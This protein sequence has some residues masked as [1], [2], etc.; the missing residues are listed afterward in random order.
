M[1]FHLFLLKFLHFYFLDAVKYKIYNEK[2]ETQS[3][4]R[5]EILLLES[6]DNFASYSCIGVN[7]QGK[8]QDKVTV[9]VIETQQSSSKSYHHQTSNKPVLAIQ[10]TSKPASQVTAEN[11]QVQ[12]RFHNQVMDDENQGRSIRYMHN[13]AFSLSR[14]VN[15]HQSLM[16]L[17]LVVRF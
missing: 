8:A 15:Y 2:F 12:F 7:T 4:S 16:L 17:L 3:E 13:S 5:L 14:F 1:E 9:E 6:K 10:P 11:D